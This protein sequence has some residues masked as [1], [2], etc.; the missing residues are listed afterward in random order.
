MTS[1]DTTH[2]K[3]VPALVELEERAFSM[4]MRMKV[5]IGI[6]LSLVSTLIG[7]DAWGIATAAQGAS[8]KMA[9]AM[10]VRIFMVAACL[11]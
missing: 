3:Y 11:G 1:S 5:P 8:S 2:E 4:R 7:V 10:A 6:S 9:A